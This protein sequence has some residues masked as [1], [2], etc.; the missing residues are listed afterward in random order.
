MNTQLNSYQLSI[1]LIV[2]ITVIMRGIVL[3]PVLNNPQRISR[4]D[5]PLL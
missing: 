4:N 2:L 5:T 3:I 1:I